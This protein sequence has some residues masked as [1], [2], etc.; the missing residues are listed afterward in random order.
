MRGIR[1]NERLLIITT[2]ETGYTAQGATVTSNDDY[3]V[4]FT[5]DS[6]ELSNSYLSSIYKEDGVWCV[7]ARNC[8]TEYARWKREMVTVRCF[9]DYQRLKCGHFSDL[10]GWQALYAMVE[11]GKLIIGE[12][13]SED[14]MIEGFKSIGITLQ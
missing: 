7:L 8:D 11:R 1:V 10:D 5:L 6:G 3:I 4:R 2:T 13:P 12:I 14:V 9:W